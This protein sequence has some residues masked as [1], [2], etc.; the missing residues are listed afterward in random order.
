MLRKGGIRNRVKVE[1]DAKVLVRQIAEVVGGVEVSLRFS[2]S[3]REHV[4]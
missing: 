1:V 4:R 3:G 2:S